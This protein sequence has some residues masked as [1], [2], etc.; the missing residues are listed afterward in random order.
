MEQLKTIMMKNL[1]IPFLAFALLTLGFQSCVQNQNDQKTSQHE[2]R[3]VWSVDKANEWYKKWGWLR[4]SDFIP[5]TAINQL[6]MWQEATFDTATI[7]RELGW[8][9]GIGMNSM[10]VYLHH[11][12]WQQ[13]PKGFK[14]RVAK[15]LDIADSHKIS[16]IFVIFDDCWNPNY[17]IGK[18]PEPK[19]GIHNSGWVRDPGDLY[20]QDPKLVDTL[21]SYVK[22]IL[23]T[24]RDD[25]RIVLWDLY[26]EPGNS[27]YD[28]K[29]LPLLK[30]VFTWGREVDPSQPL[31][32]GVWKLALKELNRYQVENSD[33][34][35]YHNYGDPADHRKW[36]D[37]L[38]GVSKRPL[39]CTEY[40]ARS[41]NSLFSNIM[42]M[43]KSEN[44]GAYNWGLVA[45]KTNTKYAWDT[46][47]KDGSE[48]KL[49]FHDIFRPDGSPYRQDEIE[50]IKVATGAN[51]R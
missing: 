11:K 3:K 35:T 10:R 50:V 45:G 48:P 21:E 27:G 12:A 1:K 23:T 18:Q 47:L 16:T 6:E 24:F 22:D 8:A 44:I 46:P 26:N 17:K 43:L 37:S 7:S 14:N 33:V 49:W 34:T 42:P 40:M 5:S 13:D 29:S 30:K 38:R 36:L 9:E 20:Y 19:P 51:S 32:A 31:S 4:G 39:I 28:N 2:T 41:R 25:K 15:Y